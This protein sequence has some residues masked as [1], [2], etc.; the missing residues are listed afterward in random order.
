MNQSK[1][2]KLV[3]KCFE[4]NGYFFCVITKVTDKQIYGESR[5]ASEGRQVPSHRQKTQKVDQQKGWV[6]SPLGW[7]FEVLFDTPIL[8]SEVLALPSCWPWPVTGATTSCRIQ[9]AG[10]A[11]GRRLLQRGHRPSSGHISIACGPSSGA[12]P[13]RAITRPLEAFSKFHFRPNQRS[14]QA[15]QNLTSISSQDSC[16]LNTVLHS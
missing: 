11:W 10:P 7:E 6:S 15:M 13:R 16:V 3:F 12:L 4:T 1:K 8:S 9:R 2:L 14:R 5:R